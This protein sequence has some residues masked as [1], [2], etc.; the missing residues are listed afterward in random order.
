M[1]IDSWFSSAQN[2]CQKSQE[3]ALQ[4]TFQGEACPVVFEG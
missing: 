4:S 1:K 2:I 3:N